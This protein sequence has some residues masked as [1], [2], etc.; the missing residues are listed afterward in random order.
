MVDRITTVNGLKRIQNGM[1]ILLNKFH[2]HKILEECKKKEDILLCHL[3]Y[4]SKNLIFIQYNQILVKI[5]QLNGMIMKMQVRIKKFTVF[6]LETKP[7]TFIF[8]LKLIKTI[9]FQN[10]VSG[11]IM[12]M[13]T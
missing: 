8:M 6:K 5:L 1:I 13:Q 7:E 10:I 3:N 2:L 12:Q 9:L 4:L 11:E